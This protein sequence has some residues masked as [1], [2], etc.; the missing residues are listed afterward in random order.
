MPALHLQATVAIWFAFCLS[1]ATLTGCQRGGSI[2]GEI[3][4]EGGGDP[5]GVEVVLRGS[6]QRFTTRS[7]GKY[8]FEGLRP[9][10]YDVVAAKPGYL[11]F[12]RY[13]VRVGPR[14]T[15][16]L[17]PGVLRREGVE[18]LPSAIEGVV[19]LVGAESSA[20][21]RVEIVDTTLETTTDA[22]GAYF[23]DNVPPG[24][25]SVRA[26]C[27]GYA[28]DEQ[29]D[30]VLGVGQVAQVPEL[31]LRP[32]TAPP[33][34]EEPTVAPA[35]ETAVV[36]G[37]LL[38]PGLLD[39]SGVEVSLDG[40]AHRMITGPDGVYQF[41]GVAYGLY[42]FDA[43]HA[44]Y[45]PYSLAIEVET[46]EVELPRILLRRA[47]SPSPPGW[48]TGQVRLEDGGDPSGAEVMLLQLD[49]AAAVDAEGHFRFDN[50]P[51]GSYTLLYSREGYVDVELYG[52][53][54]YPNQ[55]TQAPLTTLRLAI[56]PDAPGTLVGTVDLEDETDL[57][58]VM[59]AVAG[60]SAVAVSDAAGHFR[61]AA[62][63][64]GVH[65]VLASKQGYDPA[66]LSGIVV[67][68]GA[69]STLP[70]IW[71][72]K[73]RNRPRVA[74]TTPA[75]GERR[76]AVDEEL[77]LLIAFSHDMEPSSVAGALSAAPPVT[78]APL[79]AEQVAG[80]GRRVFAFALRR[81]G[82]NPLR[83]KTDYVFRVAETAR[84]LDGETMG[85][86]YLFR[87][88]T[89]GP[90]IVAVYPPDGAKGAYM[91]GDDRIAIDTNVP[92]D[93]NEWRRAITI[94]GARGQVVDLY[95]TRRGVGDRI[96]LDFDVPAEGAKYT[97]TIGQRARARDGARFENVPYRWSFST[98]SGVRAPNLDPVR[99]RPRD[100]GP[101]DEGR[102]DET[103]DFPQPAMGRNRS[104][105]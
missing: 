75:N 77:R 14:E 65:R 49:A 51:P 24:A 61:L 57:S 102:D 59:V 48:L 20:G 13:D 34:A 29:H 96:V 27:V 82:A 79:G 23:F 83:L 78:I 56:P 18:L 45:E 1:L 9:G 97:I 73:T 15:V 68:P 37:R 25:Y 22:S 33:A 84:S 88:T 8:R 41:E 91:G 105:R 39:C 62:V 40:T 28:T 7:N 67:E 47:Q 92:V 71:L 70:P 87:F 94:R 21:A 31:V 5:A 38:C 63:A 100:W 17:E 10:A 11:P 44:D 16:R 93:L 80:S 72:Q 58:G 69:E 46:A 43:S 89:G 81:D 60:T 52:V 103:A 74:Y 90:R 30:I 12:A 64:P 53:I 95:R 19:S 26:S 36:H 98:A 3:A 99:G 54:V 85:E 104:S 86:A 4:L 50:V 32:E 101:G 6:V 35:T 55:T 42:I 66:T 76:V 2:E